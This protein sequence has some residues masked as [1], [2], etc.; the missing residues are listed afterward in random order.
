MTP[1]IDDDILPLR[2]Y[3]SV[4]GLECNHIYFLTTD[5]RTERREFKLDL[6]VFKASIELREPVLKV[7]NCIRD[8]R[9]DKD[10]IILMF[11]GIIE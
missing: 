6:L 8:A 2:V 7:G 10:F 4:F 1:R 9:C 3:M 5:S 11:K